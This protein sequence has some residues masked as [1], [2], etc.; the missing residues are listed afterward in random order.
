MTSGPFFIKNLSCRTAGLGHMRK[1]AY[2]GNSPMLVAA[3]LPRTVE[4][5]LGYVRYERR[6]SAHTH[7]AYASD[8]A[9]LAAYLQAECGVDGPEA[10]TQKQLRGWAASLTLGGLQAASVRRKLA[11]AKAFYRFLHRGRHIATNPAESLRGPK[12][13]QRLPS[14]FQEEDVPLLFGQAAAE[15]SSYKA[16]L[17][18][19][20]L[21]MLYHTGIRNSE[22]CG[23]M[24]GDIDLKA[25]TVRVLGKG[26]KERLVPFVPALV[27]ALQAYSQ[28]RD[29]Q[30]FAEEAGTYFRTPRGGAMH[31]RYLYRAA[32]QGLAPAGHMRKRSPHTVR[33]SYATHLLNQGAD[34]NAVKELLGH[35]SLAATQHYTHTSVEHLKDAVRRAHPR[36]QE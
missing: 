19:T 30:A 9:Q 3:L 32:Q 31:P 2:L 17:D 24:Q 8:L 27:E 4:A 33:H 16:L 20:L 12:L 6:L 15:D 14:F 21:L 36:S 28:L 26:A 10:A 18:R 29:A 7:A 5:F 25:C 13:P 23:L 22:L 1:M 11:A 35:A 34:L